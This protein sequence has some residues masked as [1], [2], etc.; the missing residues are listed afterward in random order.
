[1]IRLRI[2]H[3][4]HEHV[5]RVVPQA[6]DD[7]LIGRV[8][9]QRVAPGDRGRQRKVARSA[10]A[11]VVA[12]SSVPASQGLSAATHARPQRSHARRTG[13]AATPHAINA[14]PTLASRFSVPQPMAA[15]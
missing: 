11:S 9:P 15:G 10:A 14:A 6:D 3:V 2:E 13:T 7:R 4:R 1:M 8:L 5:A 12:H